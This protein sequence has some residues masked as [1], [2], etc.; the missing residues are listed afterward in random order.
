MAESKE[1]VMDMSD[2]ELIANM[3]E[4]EQLAEMQSGSNLGVL[5]L[6]DKLS[7]AIATGDSKTATALYEVAA[8]AGTTLGQLLMRQV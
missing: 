2:E 8:K 5:V 7:R 3:N 4:V 1:K 6:L